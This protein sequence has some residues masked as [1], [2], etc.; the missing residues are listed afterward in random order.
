MSIINLRISIWALAFASFV[1]CSTEPQVNEFN[2]NTDPQVELERVDRNINQ[3][4]A[5]QVD[6]LSPQN[7]EHAIEAWN[8]AVKARSKNADQTQI[9][10]HIAVAQAYLDQA[11]MAA[12]VSHQLLKGPISARLDALAAR[13]QVHAAKNIDQADKEL[14]DLTEQIESNNTSNAESKSAGLEIKYR[15]IE[16]QS[17]KKEKLGMAQA[18]MQ[19]AIKEGAPKL[20]PETLVWAQKQLANDEAIITADR[21]NMTEVNKASANAIASA[22]R[23]IKMVRS[24][25]N[26]TAKNPEDR[27]R[28]LEKNELA[29]SSAENQLDKTQD[30]LEKSENKLDHA[31]STNQKLESEVWLNKKFEAARREFTKDE[32]EV[33][34]QG[35]KLLL[36]LKGL[37]FPNN[38]AVM[39]SNNF[40]LLAKVQKVIGD[41]GPSQILIEGHTDSVGSKKSNEVLS[42]ERAKSVQSY[43][44]ANKNIAADKITAEGFGDAKPIATNKTALGRAQNRRVDVIISAESF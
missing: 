24:A 38:K 32:A 37:S 10:H 30:D 44:I 35:D 5:H 33:Y 6:V 4:K 42:S 3:A 40:Q 20:T 16:L 12:N 31:K 26:S 29:M 2:Q 39:G 23:L 22:Q 11:Q 18:Y 28:Q 17:I 13:A 8:K 19:Q 9:L 14:K 1:A 25:K 15:E 41:I 7:Y 27:A 34:K 36:R 21:H 43:L